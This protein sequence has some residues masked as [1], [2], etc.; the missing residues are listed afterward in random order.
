MVRQRSL[1]KQRALFAWRSLACGTSSYR[2]LRI[3]VIPTST[4]TST[5]RLCY[6]FGPA[7][8]VVRV[9]AGTLFVFYTD[10]VSER[11]RNALR[12]EAQLHDA[13]MFAYNFSTLQTATVIEKQMF[14]TGLNATMPH[15]T[16]W[17]PPSLF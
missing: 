15:L 8:H 7:L 9:P 16:A 12:G 13:A 4:C 14:L 3:E 10:G 1:A 11:E 5:A 6:G 2:E 17:I